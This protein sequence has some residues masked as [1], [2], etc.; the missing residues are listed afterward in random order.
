[1]T[2][3]QGFNS[4][5]F[6]TGALS[7]IVT[8]M[9]SSLNG[10]S[11]PVYVRDLGLDQG[12]GT[13][14]LSLFGLGAM[15]TVLVGIVAAR[16]LTLRL[17][18]LMIAAGTGLLA[19]EINW[20]LM[21]LGGGLAG[22]GFG[23]LAVVVNRQ[24]LDGFGHRGPGMVGLVNGIYGLGA[25]VS[26]LLFVWAGGRPALVYAA[27]A[28]LALLIVPA[29]QPDRSLPPGAQGLPNL[30]QTRMLILLFGAFCALIEVGLIGLGPTALL[31]G[32]LDGLDV[33]RSVS[34][35]ALAYLLGRV[36][37]YWLTRHVGSDLLLLVALLGTALCT[38]LTLLGSPAI[39][40]VLSGC[41]VS[42]FFPTFY[43]WAIAV[44]Q[45]TRMGSVILC[46]GLT[47]VTVAPIL[48]GLI[49]S[50]AGDA[51]LFASIALLALLLGLAY[52]PVMLW[53]RRVAL[54]GDPAMSDGP[55]I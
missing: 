41:F 16:L 34:A 39:G 33:A 48:L 6:V 22:S 13:V 44:L 9:I 8:G 47:A 12:Q 54:P 5:L 37:L 28:L 35:F 55:S 11:L 51:G 32:G 45:D 2:S 52:V 26:P 20:P 50:R 43:V 7:F 25:V 40:F 36:A 1:M 30:R 38:G 31:A 27:I 24:F 14:L 49:V 23:L 3:P 19:L 18:L 46:A 10:V 15:V 21:L 17:G 4:R 42:L 53:A 29:V